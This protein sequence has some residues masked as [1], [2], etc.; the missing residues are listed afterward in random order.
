MELKLIELLFGLYFWLSSF[1]A[2]L[3]FRASKP[4][5]MT[6]LISITQWDAFSRFIL[7]FSTL[8]L[9]AHRSNPCTA[10]YAF[11]TARPT[12]ENNQTSDRWHY[13]KRH[14]ILVRK[15]SYNVTK[16]PTGNYAFLLF[17]TG[18]KIRGPCRRGRR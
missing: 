15:T 14:E 17:V 11:E 5:N 13:I 9:R 16:R 12:Q 1:Q 2:E 4:A 18:P 6:L 10:T 3:P 8:L 7:M